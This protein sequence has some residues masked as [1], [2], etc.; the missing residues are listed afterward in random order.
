[1]YFDITVPKLL[2]YIYMNDFGHTVFRV[3]ENTFL[4]SSI[5]V[6]VA[7][8]KTKAKFYQKRKSE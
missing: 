5:L 7:I 8:A 2:A 4:T 6:E 3:Y 1:M